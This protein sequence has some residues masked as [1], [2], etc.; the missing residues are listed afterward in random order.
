MVVFTLMV[1]RPHGVTAF[2]ALFSVQW[3]DAATPEKEKLPLQWRELDKTPFLKLLVVKALRPD[4][5]CVALSSFVEATLPEGELYTRCDSKLTSFLILEDAYTDSSAHVPLYLITSPGADVAPE[6]DKLAASHSRTKGVNVHEIS[7]GQGQVC[8][9]FS[10]LLCCGS[11]RS[12]PR[13]M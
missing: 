11:C 12:P 3:Y 10:F 5:L 7:L 6:L 8:C 2:V 9:V 13:C 4:R 1:A